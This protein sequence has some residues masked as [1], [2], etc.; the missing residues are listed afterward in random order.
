MR[1]LSAQSYGRMEIAPGF[2]VEFQKCSDVSEQLISKST[3]HW[4]AIRLGKGSKNTENSWPS[5]P[6]YGLQKGG[7]TN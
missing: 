6:I 7:R 2:W 4:H 3:R 1:S 5:H